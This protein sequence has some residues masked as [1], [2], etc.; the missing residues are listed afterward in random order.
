L[1]AGNVLPQEAIW[2]NAYTPGALP[3]WLLT[4]PAGLSGPVAVGCSPLSLPERSLELALKNA[5]ENLA[6]SRH[7]QI[8][9]H[10][11]E[12]FQDRFIF[13]VENTTEAVDS[14]LV[15]ATA[16]AAVVLDTLVI[17]GRPDSRTVRTYVLVS[18]ENA[19][20]PD[21]ARAIHPPA[22]SGPPVWFT[23]PPQAT[24]YIFGVGLAGH[25]PGVNQAWA[26]VEKLA[27]LDLA[28]QLQVASDTAMEDRM[29][30]VRTTVSGYKEEKITVE[31]HH[32]VIVARHYDAKK[33]Q[34]YAVA[35]M[36]IK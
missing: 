34:F 26:A 21:A 30:S 2:Q 17:R 16:K 10:R 19:T 15:A 25:Y 3:S 20:L 5:Y 33:K 11:W 24:G 22:Q 28:T 9:A 6:G 7:M 14:S 27:R 8:V 29:S 1:Q 32:A 31:L 12:I 23:D 4:L 13:P 18:M 35:R 36:P